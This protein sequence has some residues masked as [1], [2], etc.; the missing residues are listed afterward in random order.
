MGDQVKFIDTTVRDGNQSLWAFN[1]KTGMMLSVLPHLDEA[2]FDSIEFYNH[3]IQIKKLGKDLGEDALEWLKRG[4][5]LNNK[6]ELRLHGGIRGGLS[7]IPLSV[8]KLMVD[9]IVAHGITL[10]RSSN[11]WNDFPEHAP[12]VEDLRKAGMRTVVN[13]IYSISPR[14]TDAYYRERIAKA[15]ALN[16]YRICFK[17][18]GGLLTP[19]RTRELA[20]IFKESA[21]DV[22]LEFHA[23]SNNGLAPLNALEVAKAGIKYIHTSIP[24]VANGTSQPSIFNVAQN[25]RSLGFDPV[26]DEAPLRPAS[27]KLTAIAHRHHLPIGAPRLFDQE[28][29]GHQVP[30]GMLSNLAYQLKLV[31]MEHRLQEALEETVRVRAEFGYPIMVTPLSQFVGSQAAINVILGE[32]YKLASDAVIQFALGLW[33]REAVTAMDQDVRAKILDRSRARE[34]A[35][36]QPPQPSLKEVRAKFGRNISDEEMVLRFFGGDEAYEVMGKASAPKDFLSVRHP[37]ATLIDE[38]S[39]RRNFRR[40]V[41]QKGDVSVTLQGGSGE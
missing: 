32:R 40:V 26:I 35:N 39:K 33:G 27:E 10:N 23:H 15:A 20:P 41:V 17:D 22:E 14:H 19:E 21:G 13:V 37:V 29:Y 36:W 7:L 28:I 1:M 5:A 2:G 34:L 3:G 24:P 30:G 12:E 6:T 31:G 4:A 8:R 9:I 18:V 16:P 38:L 25:L 11:A